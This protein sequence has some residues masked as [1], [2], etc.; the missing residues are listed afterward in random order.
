MARAPLTVTRTG[1]RAGLD[2]TRAI[3]EIRNSEV[4][5]GIPAENSLREGE[6]MNNASLLFIHTHG[7]PLHNIPARPVIEPAVDSVRKLVA[8]EL[9]QAATLLIDRN[10]IA[11]TAHLKRAGQIGSNAAKRWFTNPANGWPPNAP[12][13]IRGKGSD[14]PLIDTG[15]LRRSIT[16]SVTQGTVEVP[17]AAAPVEVSAEEAAILG[18][19]AEEIAGSL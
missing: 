17:P 16:Y 15:Q 18:G 4:F 7:S 9:A 1:G 14:K 10:P 13:T 2:L 3:R 5:V 6:E 19:E 8:G 12:S 11:A